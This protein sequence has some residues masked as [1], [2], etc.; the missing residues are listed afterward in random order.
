MQTNDDLHTRSS[1]LR[2]FFDSIVCANTI[3]VHSIFSRQ[4]FG[5]N[6]RELSICIFSASMQVIADKEILF[7]SILNEP[8]ANKR[9]LRSKKSGKVLAVKNIPELVINQ[10]VYAKIT[11]FCP[12][13]ARITHLF[14]RWCDVLFFGVTARYVIFIHAYFWPQTLSNIVFIFINSECRGINIPLECVTNLLNG[15]HIQTKFSKRRGFS[16]AYDEMQLFIDSV[17]STKIATASKEKNREKVEVAAPRR[18]ARLNKQQTR[19]DVR[20]SARLA[21]KTAMKK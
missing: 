18:S 16:K 20:R 8:M 6:W 13:P 11:G 17:K 5:A 21:K 2:F 10:P 7:S 9:K 3:H 12:W 1:M 15:Q 4:K 19:S 14:G